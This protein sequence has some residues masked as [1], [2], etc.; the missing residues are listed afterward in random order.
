[1]VDGIHTGGGRVRSRAPPGV[2]RVKQHG[3]L[4][5]DPVVRQ[6]S[7]ISEEVFIGTLSKGA[8]GRQNN[9][10]RKRG[11]SKMPGA[12]QQPRE[13]GTEKEAGQAE[14]DK[15]LDQLP[16]EQ[17]V[18][19]AERT[20]EQGEEEEGGK[21]DRTSSQQWRQVGK[22]SDEGARKKEGEGETVQGGEENRE[23]KT[24]N[25][26]SG[27]NK[28]GENENCGQDRRE[29]RTES[30]KQ[31]W[32]LRIG[33]GQ[34]WPGEWKGNENRVGTDHERGGSGI[35]EEGMVIG[36]EEVASGESGTRQAPYRPED[37]SAAQSSSVSPIPREVSYGML[38]E[39]LTATVS[40]YGKEMDSDTAD[41]S[42]TDT[43]GDSQGVMQQPE[44]HEEGGIG[45]LEEEQ[46]RNRREASLD[47][48]LLQVTNSRTG[49]GLGEEPSETD[50]EGV[51][52]QED[53]TGTEDGPAEE[54][55][56]GEEQ[57]TGSAVAFTS[58]DLE[59]AYDQVRWEFLL[60]GMA[61]RG[62]G[63]I[64]CGWVRSMLKG[65]TTV[66][67]VNGVR[68][69]KLKITRWTHRRWN[70]QNA[71]LAALPDQK[72]AGLIW[73]LYRLAIP[74]AQWLAARSRH[75][76]QTC[77]VGCGQVE[78]VP[79]LS[80]RC[81]V[82][83]S[84]LEWWARE[85]AEHSP[86][87]VTEEDDVAIRL[88]ALM[89]VNRSRPEDLVAAETI[90]AAVLWTLW[91]LRNERCRQGTFPPL[92]AYQERALENI[93]TAI[94]ADL[95]RSMRAGEQKEKGFWAAWE[96]Y[97]QL[98]TQD[99]QTGRMLFGPLLTRHAPVIDA[100]EESD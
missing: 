1:M 7:R 49:D 66:M 39:G 30:L 94:L 22:E 41:T 76:D 34:G 5:N 12:E 59:K 73:K 15:V 18:T 82:V 9:L 64:F 62:I 24:A 85:L 88:G 11:R 91:T 17:R 68:S 93:R 54:R 77:A 43:P 69:D 90:R 51:S 55:I 10:R 6:N 67:Q 32:M 16:G 19:V 31:S 79:H 46:R 48:D 23:D 78:T 42:D 36:K 4:P 25:L 100:E 29:D 35:Q 37:V 47:S 56:L 84:F 3:G 2:S 80:V 63:G 75:K 95:H 83:Q 33:H 58:I 72:Q 89:K 21:G 44:E 98:L 92:Q 86:L 20:Q 38:V 81:P 96:P 27:L 13:V 8:S 53:K 99:L 45:E 70:E 50:G 60:Q 71:I 61:R 74:T 26:G 57:C 87:N 52:T 14:P 28:G 65:A 97:S 40:S